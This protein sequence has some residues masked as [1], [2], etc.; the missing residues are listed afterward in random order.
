M[1]RE[2]HASLCRV[3]LGP[4]GRE[5]LRG[6]PA[7]QSGAGSGGGVWGKERQD[8]P[9]RPALSSHVHS[10]KWPFRFCRQPQ[11]ADWLPLFCL[12]P[13]WLVLAPHQGPTPF[14]LLACAPWLYPASRR[15]ELDTSDAR[16]GPHLPDHLS[17]QGEYL[18]GALKLCNE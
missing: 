2:A 7:S 15:L 12:V 4:Q 17:P 16:A 5:Q 14:S 6:V 8:G 11:S 13:F 3:C 9:C 18:A 1:G 10:T